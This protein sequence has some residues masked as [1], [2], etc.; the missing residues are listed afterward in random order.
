MAFVDKQSDKLGKLG[1]IRR[2]NQSKYAS[3]TVVVRK[4]DEEGNYT[5]L[6]KCGGYRPL[7][8]DT[9]LDRYQLPLIETIFNEMKGAKI[10]TKLDLRSRYHQMPL[11]ES[12]RSK[13]A[14]WGAQHIL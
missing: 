2:S 1:F 9:N 8:L 7:N 12:D 4:K 3:S 5:N 6:R 10:F 11:R 13:T 14:F